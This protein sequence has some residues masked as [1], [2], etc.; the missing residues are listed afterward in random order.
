MG[1][2]RAIGGGA[3]LLWLKNTSGSLA[4]GTDGPAMDG[5]CRSGGEGIVT[6]AFHPLDRPEQIPRRRPGCEKLQADFIKGVTEGLGGV[7]CDME[8]TEGDPHCRG[9][10][11]SRGAPDGQIVG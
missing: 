9:D 6:A 8:C 3:P 11:Y 7:C 10:A 2:H 4:G 1:G 5:C